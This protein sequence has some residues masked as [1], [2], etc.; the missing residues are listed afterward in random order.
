[1]VAGALARA[2]LAPVAAGA[3][4]VRAVMGTGRSG[5]GRLVGPR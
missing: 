1:V 3:G 5:T 2:G 4:T